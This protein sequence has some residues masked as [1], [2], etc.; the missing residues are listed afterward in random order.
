VAGKTIDD[1][2]L[3]PSTILT[4][5]GAS[6]TN[7]VRT[8]E[9]YRFVQDIEDLLAT[10]KATF[11]EDTLRGMQTSAEAR[12]EVSDNMRRALKNIEDSI[13]RPRVGNFSRRRYEGYG[14]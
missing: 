3:D 4:R 12:R 2:N 1:L 9:W 14:Q 5:S 11:A 13:Y 7:D 10:G 8:T 6:S